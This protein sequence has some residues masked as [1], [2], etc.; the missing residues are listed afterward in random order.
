M[1]HKQNPQTFME[2]QAATSTTLRINETQ[3]KVDRLIGGMEINQIIHSSSPGIHARGR[4]RVSQGY[5]YERTTRNIPPIRSE[6]ETDNASRTRRPAASPPTSSPTAHATTRMPRRSGD[7]EGVPAGALLAGGSLPRRGEARRGRRGWIRAG[8]GVR[9]AR[10][11]EESRG[12]I[13]EKRNRRE[14]RREEEMWHRGHR[15]PTRRGTWRHVIGGTELGD[16]GFSREAH[17]YWVRW[18]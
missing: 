4:D 7:E 1:G 11:V 5:E 12:E 18:A 14:R 8:R 17:R 15:M 9:T 6:P 10:E 16:L 13:R 2:T 3:K